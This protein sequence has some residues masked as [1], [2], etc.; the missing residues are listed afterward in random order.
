VIAW[1][2]THL[3]LLGFLAVLLL[4]VLCSGAASCTGIHCG[5]C[6]R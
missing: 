1:I 2:S 4:L 3:L 6:R 5:G